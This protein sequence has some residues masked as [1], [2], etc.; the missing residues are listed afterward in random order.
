M[1]YGEA[2]GPCSAP[3]IHRTPRGHVHNP[4]VIWRYDSQIA[5]PQE[6]YAVRKPQCYHW[7]LPSP[8]ECLRPVNRTC[9]HADSLDESMVKTS[10]LV[11]CPVFMPSM[12]K[13]T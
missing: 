4:A 10:T 13:L 6:L 2:P 5:E 9:L 11:H 3:T 1:Q 12:I 7:L 8:N